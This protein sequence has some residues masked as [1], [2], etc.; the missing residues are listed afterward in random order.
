VEDIVSLQKVESGNLRF[1]FITPE[2]LINQAVQGATASAAESNIRLVADSKP[3]LPTLHVDI[4]RI[5][6]IFDNLIGNAIKFSQPDSEIKI[7][8]GLD[9]EAIK[10]SVQDHGAGIPP[11][12]LNKLFEKFYQVGRP[13]GSRRYKG[14]GLGLAIVKQIVEAHQGWVAVE[15]QLNQGSTFFFWLPVY[16]SDFIS[17]SE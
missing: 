7:A 8:A 17:E 3:D 13:T 4:D 15:S 16:K 11:E 10:F 9:G 2:Q 6:Q 1:D 14:S 5:G 12:A